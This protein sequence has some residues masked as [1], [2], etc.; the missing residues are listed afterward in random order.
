[1]PWGRTSSWDPDLP[2]FGYHFI[3]FCFWHHFGAFKQ[4]NMVK[5]GHKIPIGRLLHTALPRRQ[6]VVDLQKILAEHIIKYMSPSCHFS[7]SSCFI[8][9]NLVSFV[10]VWRCPCPRIRWY[11]VQMFHLTLDQFIRRKNNVTFHVVPFRDLSP[12]S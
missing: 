8:Y 10:Y 3:F 7:Q 1:M 6:V 2:K 5:K 11:I 9:A 4:I 12:F